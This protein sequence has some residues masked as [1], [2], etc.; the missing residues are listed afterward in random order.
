MSPTRTSA[1]PIFFEPP[2]LKR[3]TLEYRWKNSKLDVKSAVDTAQKFLRNRGFIISSEEGENSVKLTGATRREKYDVRLVKIT[4]S[5]SKDE[6]SIKFEAGDRMRP[7]LRFSSVFS[8]WGGGAI[9][10]KEL[11][12]AEQYDKIEEEFWREM[13]PIVSASSSR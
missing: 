13:E 9:V 2:R 4:I 6:L 7:I 8:V 11:K 12:T 3:G 5:R 1:S 10:L